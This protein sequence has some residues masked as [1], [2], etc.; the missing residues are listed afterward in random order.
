MI[1]N[2]F[3]ERVYGRDLAALFESQRLFKRESDV[4]QQGE[5]F[6]LIGC[7]LSGMLCRYKTQSDGRQQIVS[8]LIPGDLF[9]L[10]VPRGIIRQHG[11]S[12][13]KDSIVTFA[14][15]DQIRDLARANTDVARVL[16]LERY[17]ELTMAQECIV[18]CSSR[19][20]S[21]RVARLICDFYWRLR[22]VGLMSEGGGP[23]DLRQRILAEATG[24][25]VVH[26]NRVLK[27]LR[28]DG[29]AMIERGHLLVPDVA[30]LTE[31]CGFDPAYLLLERRENAAG[32]GPRA[33]GSELLSA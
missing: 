5:R 33:S 12:A 24:L 1:R 9:D 23:F 13:V 17:A 29:L 15:E 25:T 7:V 14:P 28:E 21:E 26:M 8:F 6:K 22:A 20:A 30:R 11:V 27:Q 32:A 31:A 10:N 3:G 18:N 2:A 4:F 19:S 16:S